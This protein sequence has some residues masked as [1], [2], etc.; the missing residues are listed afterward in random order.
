[1]R[2]GGS[3]ACA[4]RRLRKRTNP[5]NP[6]GFKEKS[7]T[8]PERGVKSGLPTAWRR[9]RQQPGEFDAKIFQRWRKEERFSSG[10]TL[11]RSVAMFF[12]EVFRHVAGVERAGTLRT[13][14]R[15]AADRRFRNSQPFEGQNGGDCVGVSGK[16]GLLRQGR[17]PVRVAGTHRL[18]VVGK[19][20][21]GIALGRKRSIAALPAVLRVAGKILGRLRRSR[22]EMQGRAGR[23]QRYGGRASAL[24]PPC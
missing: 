21:G 15:A 7:L 8:A 17:L 19:A 24:R 4:R 23:R 16:C 6:V 5:S 11:R 14:R 22:R 2:Q 20:C 9:S 13:E 3:E 10:A 12:G 18:A 1:M